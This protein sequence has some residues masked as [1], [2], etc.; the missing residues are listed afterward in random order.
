MHS[1]KAHE[2]QHLVYKGNH[3]FRFLIDISE[4]LVI[5]CNFFLKKLRVGAD[6]SKRSFQFVAGIGD[7]LFFGIDHFFDR[8]CQPAGERP[9]G[10]GEEK[11]SGKEKTAA[12]IECRECGAKSGSTA[13]Q[14]EIALAGVV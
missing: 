13:D 9:S 8:A 7:K 10:N 3:A 12:P 5:C 14:N 6:D 4:M 2:R 11:Y 1:V